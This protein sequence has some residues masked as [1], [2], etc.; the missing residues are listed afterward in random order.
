MPFANLTLNCWLQIAFYFAVLL[1]LSLPLGVFMAR[2]FEGQLPRGALKIEGAFYKIAGIRA[3]DEMSWRSYAGAVLL[4]NLVGLLFVHLLQRAQAVLPLNPQ[5]LGAVSPDS[6]FNTAI[7]FVTPMHW[8]YAVSRV[9][10]C[11]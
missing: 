4:F 9:F 11:G 1:G 7:S 5:K 3:N 6:S 8:L 2:V 10:S